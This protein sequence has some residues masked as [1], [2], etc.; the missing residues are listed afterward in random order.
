M[1]KLFSAREIGVLALR[2][3]GVVS[4][5]ETSANEGKLLVALQQLDLILSEK[6]GTTRLW[7]FVPQELTFS[8]TADAESV[9]ITSLLGANNT[10][11]MFKAAYNDDTDDEITLLRRDEFDLYKNGGLFPFITGRVLY[12]ASDGDDTYSAYLRPVPTEA[13][14]IRIT[15]QR[16][17]PSVSDAT[18][19]SSNLAHGFEKPWQRWMVYALA[20]DIGDGP[21]ARIPETRLADWRGIAHESW[22]KVNAY[23]G[24]GQRKYARFTRAYNG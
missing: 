15:G 8:Y 23:R 6:S 3:I 13:I 24:G 5:L 20:A 11:D 19:S 14:T 16:F 9:N 1:S 18:S 17:S 4:A 7:N 2:K 12:V 21:L 22:V 10:L